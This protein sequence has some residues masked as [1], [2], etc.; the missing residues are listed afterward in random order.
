MADDDAKAALM[1]RLRNQFGDLDLAG[2]LSDGKEEDASSEDSSVH[3]PSQAEL[4]AWQQ[5]QFNKGREKLQAKNLA[6]KTPLE[7]RRHLQNKHEDTDWEDILPQPNLQGQESLFFPST[8]NE[9][10]IFEVIGPHPLLMKF[11]AKG[12]PEVLGGA[13][14]RLYSSSHGDGLSFPYLLDAIRGYGGP[15]VM[16]IRAIPSAKHCYG[17]KSS[18]SST[19]GFYTTSTWM[20]SSQYYGT[21][22]CFLFSIGTEKD[23]EEIRIIRPKKDNSSKKSTDYMYCYPSRMNIASRNHVVDSTNGAVHGI[24]IGG[25]AGQPRLHITESMEGCRALGYDTVFEPGQLLMP[26]FGDSLYYFDIVHLEM[27]GVGGQ[28]WIDDAL[29]SRETEKERVRANL[30]KV[31]RVDK[32]QLLDDLR[33]TSAVFEHQQHT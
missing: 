18:S 1:A 30:Q 12:D 28:S 19:L 17:N 33:L 11:A 6:A 2:M 22:E 7:K 27:W 14:K 29:R 31:Q 20:D 24:G 3:E 4:I 5:A 32:E 21:G 8:N 26:D 10:G 23:S 9:D 13:W 25:N 15:T 16:L